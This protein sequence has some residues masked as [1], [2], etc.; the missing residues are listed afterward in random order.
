MTVPRLA[1]AAITVLALTAAAALTTQA[2]AARPAPV[3]V[4]LWAV[5]NVN[6]TLA[7][8]NGATT[9]QATGVDGEYEVTF[10]R[11]ITGCA[12]AAT[13]GEAA[14]FTPGP[15]DAITFGVAPANTGPATVFLLEYDSILARDSYSSGFHLI[16]TC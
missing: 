11:D 6:G 14:A 13:A 3:P 8:S 2:A 9:S 10:N 15:D 12:Y 7:R 5:V 16:I 4:V 1:A